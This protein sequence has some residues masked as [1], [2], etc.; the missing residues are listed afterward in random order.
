M[1]NVQQRTNPGCLAAIA[2]AQQHYVRH[3][4]EASLLYQLVEQHAEAFFA[5]LAERGATLPKFVRDEFEAYLRC[6]RLEG[7]FLRVKCTECRHEHLVAF[8]CK[9]RA[10]CPSCGARCMVESGRTRSDGL[11]DVRPRAVMTTSR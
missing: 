4:P 7:G 10:F 8:S 1:V 6:G 5:H 11:H 2:A 3:R 9:R